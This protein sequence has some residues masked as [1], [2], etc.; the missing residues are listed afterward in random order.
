MNADEPSSPPENKP[1][2][3]QNSKNDSPPGEKKGEPENPDEKKAPEKKDGEGK[4]DAQKKD[5]DQK[6]H[7]PP[8]YKRRGFIPIVSIILV[9]LMVAGIIVWLIVR[10]FVSTDDAY[11]DG[12]V[13]QISP[14]A[15]AQ[16]IALHIQDNQLVHKGDLLI[17]L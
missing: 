7:K 15:A 11:V 1:A 4:N 6:P 12:H 8:L 3:N 10:Q 14:R 13:T 9:I 17:E 16:V 5:E 2:E